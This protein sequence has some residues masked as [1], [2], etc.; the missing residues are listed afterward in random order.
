MHAEYFKLS[1][2]TA[3]NLNK[4]KKEGRRIIAVG[5]TV[6]RVLET[7]ACPSCHP[8]QFTPSLS[9]GGVSEG[10]EKKLSHFDYAQCDNFLRPRSGTTDIFICPGYK[11]KFIDALITNFH[12]PKSTLMM[13]VSAFAKTPGNKS[14][15]AGKKFINQAYKIAIKRKYRFYS[16]GDAMLIL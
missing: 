3:K 7:C 11:F 14:A 8:E 6:T 13:L 9:K 2:K 15:L 10:K 1:K 16:F 12:V 5:T 4:A